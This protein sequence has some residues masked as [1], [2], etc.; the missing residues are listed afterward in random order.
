MLTLSVGTTTDVVSRSASTYETDIVL[1]AL[2]SSLWCVGRGCSAGQAHTLLV[3]DTKSTK[4]ML[5]YGSLKPS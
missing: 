1:V 2:L 3:Y 4:N 5:F